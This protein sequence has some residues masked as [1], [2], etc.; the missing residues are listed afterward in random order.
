MG[1]PGFDEFLKL[2]RFDSDFVGVNRAAQG[3]PFR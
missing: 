2:E 3:R 1:R